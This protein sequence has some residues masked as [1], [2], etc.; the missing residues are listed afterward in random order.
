M[1]NRESVIRLSEFTLCVHHQN[2]LGT[3]RNNEPVLRADLRLSWRMCLLGRAKGRSKSL[4]TGRGRAWCSNG[5]K[6]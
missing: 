5:P 2:P 3:Q 4:A 6:E 1:Q